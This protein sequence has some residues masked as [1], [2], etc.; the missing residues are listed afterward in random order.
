MDGFISNLSNCLIWND[1]KSP[2]W[3]EAPYIECPAQLNQLVTKLTAINLFRKRKVFLV[4][5]DLTFK[6]EEGIPDVM[7]G[8][9][10]QILGS[11][12]TVDQKEQ[13]ICLLEVIASGS[14]FLAVM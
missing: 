14:G 12:S 11:S 5:V 3:L 2:G 7:R 1:R 6:D 8:E 4:P 9:E 10:I 13:L